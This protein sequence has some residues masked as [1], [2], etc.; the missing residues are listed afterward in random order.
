[1][2][3][4]ARLAGI[5]LCGVVSALTNTIVVAK[6]AIAAGRF[7]PSRA[8]VAAFA[9]VAVFTVGAGRVLEAFRTVAGTAAVNPIGTLVAATYP[10]VVVAWTGHAVWPVVV[11]LT[12]IAVRALKALTAAEALARALQTIVA[13][14]SLANIRIVFFLRIKPRTS[15]AAGT[16]ETVVALI[17]GLS[18]PALI[19][20]H[21][22]A[23]LVASSAAIAGV[24]GPTWALSM[25]VFTKPA[26]ETLVTFRSGEV[27]FAL[28]AVLLA[29]FGIRI[30]NAISITGVVRSVGADVAIGS[31]VLRQ[32]GLAVGGDV[33]AVIAGALAAP[34]LAVV[35]GSVTKAGIVG[36][37]GALLITALAVIT[38]RAGVASGPRPV[39]PALTNGVACLVAATRPSAAT[40]L[41][42]GFGTGLAVVTAK[43]LV[44]LIT[45]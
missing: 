33:K 34:V 35:A 9:K 3:G 15:L 10:T 1:M 11:V 40:H 23:S 13:L 43:A 22:I 27:A 21:A 2:E 36:T 45:G 20:A 31:A 32:A 17:T 44:A 39:F 6:A 7:S 4:E 8:R 12:G 41:V 37:A 38:R 42:S 25:A 18:R 14:T 28:T 16:K 30:A 29:R 5:T 19:A 26:R 24:F